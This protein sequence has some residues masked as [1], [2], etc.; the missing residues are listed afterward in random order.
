MRPH[1]SV[2]APALSVRQFPQEIHPVTKKGELT[3][4]NL[5]ST[6]LFMD[7]TLFAAC[8]MAGKYY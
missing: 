8:N 4:M 5:P 7:L 2:H 1:F 3:E 6:H